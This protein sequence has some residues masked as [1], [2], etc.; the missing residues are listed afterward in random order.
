MRS[1][2]V[3]REFSH[4]RRVV[5][6]VGTNLLST[7]DGIDLAFMETIVQQMHALIENGYQPLLVSSGAI[8]MGAKELG[9]RKRVRT[10]VRRQAFASIGQPLLMHN[11]RQMFSTYGHVVA[12]LLLTRYILDNRKSFLNLKNSVEQLLDLGVIP[13]FNENDSV[14]T[15][16]IGTAFGDNDTLSALIA[17]KIDADLLIILTDIDGLYNGNPKTDPE[18]VLIHEV[19]QVD[20][21]VRSWASGAGSLFSTGGMRTKLTAAQIASKAGC[22]SIIAKGTEP[23]VLERILRGEV[24]GTYIQ[25]AERMAQ[26][27]R[28]IL[29]SSAEGRII[30]DQGAVSA[31]RA[32]KSLL[33]SGIIRVEGVFERG[34]VVMINDVAKAVPSFNSSE[35]EALIGMHSS[36]IREKIGTHRRDVIARPED[37][38]FI[39]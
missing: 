29:Q 18:A 32:H 5:I 27:D 19:D 16:E 3:S 12:Q 30:I 14:S 23:Q 24:M 21:T 25:P 28:W 33:P 35:I 11:Y 20:D 6:K 31:L 13:I 38:V 1:T 7:D 37:I 22:G 17:S 15:D 34:T 8:G 4:V 10:I 36:D 2:L 9:Y 26:R 39:G